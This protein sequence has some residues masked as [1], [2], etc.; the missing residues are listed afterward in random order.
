MNCP[1][2][3]KQI[4]AMTGLQELQKF[5]KH[6][7]TCKKNPSIQVL[8][9]PKGDIIEMRKKPTLFDSLNIRHDSGQ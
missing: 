7:R 2:C 6:L 9:T 4:N 1:F 3:N 8:A 5:T